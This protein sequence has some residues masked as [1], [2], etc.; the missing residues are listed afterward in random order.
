MWKF[1]IFFV[2][3]L[4]FCTIFSQIIHFSVSLESKK[5]KNFQKLKRIQTKRAGILRVSSNHY[6]PFMYQNEIGQFY[7]GIEYKLLEAVAKTTSMDLVFQK[8]TGSVN[9]DHLIFK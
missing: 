2:K 7:N 4:I 6:E 5:S 1:S 3:F 8:N 9:D